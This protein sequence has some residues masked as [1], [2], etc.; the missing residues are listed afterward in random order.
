M[1][2]IMDAQQLSNEQI[3]QLAAQESG[4]AIRVDATKEEV[5]TQLSQSRK[6]FE[7]VNT[8][9]RGESAEPPIQISLSEIVRY[10]GG[11]NPDYE[12]VINSLP[13]TQEGRALQDLVAMLKTRK[14]QDNP[15]TRQ[16]L[17]QWGFSSAQIDTFF[18]SQNSKGTVSPQFI[19]DSGNQQGTKQVG[20]PKAYV[21]N[22]KPETQD[23]KITIE[24]QHLTKEEIEAMKYNAEMKPKIEGN[25]DEVNTSFMV[26]EGMKDPNTGEYTLPFVDSDVGRAFDAHALAKVSIS[27]QLTQLINLLDNGVDMNRG[28]LHTARLAKGPNDPPG[29]DFAGS[30]GGSFILLSEPGKSINEG[31]IHYVLVNDAYYDGIDRLQKAYPKVKFIRAD[32]ARNEL[33]S[34]KM[35]YDKK[36]TT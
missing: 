11:E 4:N 7:G 6:I 9:T 16:T 18:P 32:Q 28:G 2:I 30:A 29:P 13:D 12:K 34:I 19:P 1:M 22:E 8:R 31:G 10:V 27:N 14:A 25:L 21:F 17:A 3:Q 26:N 35:E 20:A 15:Q 5:D 23:K 24:A 33:K 36:K